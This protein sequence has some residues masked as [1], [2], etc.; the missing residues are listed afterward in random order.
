MESIETKQ[1]NRF[2]FLYALYN[3]IGIENV[4]A[5]MYEIGEKL[6]FDDISVRNIVEY[7]EGEGL[8]KSRA[9]GGFISG[10]V[11]ITHKGIKEIED[12]NN[13]PSKPTKNFPSNIIYIMGD[14]VGGRKVMGDSFE[15]ITNSTIINKS[16]L[17]NAFNRLKNEID[18]ETANSLV[19]IAKEI[20]K[21]NDPAASG[22]FGNFTEEL[23]KPNPDKGRLKSFWT[24]LERILPTVADLA[25]KIIPLFI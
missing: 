3:E 6:G 24:G 7:L 9:Y 17:Q 5:N 1:K 2:R 25:G 22:L 12:A 10:K 4:P 11:A 20:E 15:N 14:Y 23:S 19:R 8:T 16:S 13:T 18:E 21:A